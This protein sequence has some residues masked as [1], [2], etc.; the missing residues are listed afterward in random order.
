MNK[1]IL[2]FLS[3]FFGLSVFGQDFI[4]SDYNWNDD[5]FAI[6]CPDSL[7]EEPEVNLFKKRIS[8]FGFVGDDFVERYISH[9]V[10]YL[11]SDEAIE[12]NNKI[13]LPLRSDES[14]ELSKARV[15]NPDGKVIELSKDDINT[16]DDEDGNL[17]YYY[18]FKGL[19]LGSVIEYLYIQQISPEYSGKRI[20]FQ[21]DK[22]QLNASFEIISPWNLVFAYRGS[23]GF[24]EMESD[25]TNEDINR[26]HIEW[27]YI[28]KYKKEDMSYYSIN[29][30]QV[31]YK[32]DHNLST[33]KKD[34]VSYGNMADI[35]ITNNTTGSKS[36]TKIISKW[37]KESGAKKEADTESQ[38]RALE[39]Y[40][41]QSIAIVDVY[42][43]DLNDLVFIS[44]NKVMSPLGFVKIM[45]LSCNELNIEYEI[46]MTCNRADLK[47]DSKFEAYN[48]LDN[49]ILY[50]PEID[51]YLD[52]SENF[53]ALGIVNPFLQDGYGVFFQRVQLGDFVSGVSEIKLM[54]GTSAKD[55]Q[56][57]MIM[58]V[59]VADDFTNLIVDYKSLSRGHFASAIQPYYD[60]MD[61][62][63]IEET[64]KDQVRW[65]SENV[66]VKSVEI[67]NSGYQ[68]LGK[69]P[70]EVNAKFETDEY[71]V[72]ARDKY[73]IKLGLL[74]GPQA[75]MYQETARTR[76]VDTDFRKIYHRVIKFE[77]PEGYRIS[78][79]E[80]I[81]IN[82]EAT[83]DKGV[84]AGF[85]SSYTID[86]NTLTVLCDEFYER[87]HYEVDEFE[88]Y[89]AVINSAADFNK[90]VIYLEKV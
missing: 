80:S 20:I 12:G 46:A 68:Y 64:N 39:V 17:T 49:Y 62:E 16:S 38:L 35:I 31:I 27:D 78:N 84:Y 28:P 88:A 75:E 51:K 72:K 57:D 10:A 30:L 7:K 37:M 66:D 90:I 65:I 79:A 60:L 36:D 8:E 48:Y 40:F 43:T 29:A 89:R 50:F 61:P 11:G 15:I 9:R 53:G 41:K 83:N 33:G 26:L 5:P 70:F 55:S 24:D 3:L 45:A 59:K 85:N 42:S 56:H 86:G 87:V 14:L 69:E 34:V 22:I 4:T 71:I 1:S 74:I 2:L 67:K 6:V 44:K 82:V 76:P 52:P 21:N 23:N 19:V 18:A 73:L 32:L 58:D 47:F 63:V 25:T 54:R 81:I 77:I 13:Y